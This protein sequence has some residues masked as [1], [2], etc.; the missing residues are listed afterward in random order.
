MA[1][2]YLYENDVEQEQH[3]E[4][5]RRLARELFIPESDI[6][7]LY[8]IRLKCIKN[9]A[10]IRDYLVVLV[11]RRVKDAVRNKGLHSEDCNIWPPQRQ[12]ELPHV[13]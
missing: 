1:E 7:R 13:T 10:R 12:H 3:A 4:A 2:V 11:S 8:E 6:R 5:I 9:G